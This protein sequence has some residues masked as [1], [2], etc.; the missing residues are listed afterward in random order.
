MHPDLDED[1]HDIKIL[2]F[3]EIYNFY[4]NFLIRIHLDAQII[5]FY[6]CQRES[7]RRG[8]KG[9]TQYESKRV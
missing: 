2:H 9:H 6:L 4:L 8:W 7:N 1:K 3:D 5:V